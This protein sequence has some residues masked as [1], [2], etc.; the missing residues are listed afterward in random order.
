[1]AEPLALTLPIPPVVNKLWV[2][3][4]TSTGARMV[5]RAASEAW[6]AEA[7]WTVAS[8]RAGA[9]IADRF[10]ALIVVPETPADIDARIKPILDA[11]QHGGAIANDKHCRSLRVE[12]DEGMESGIVRVELTPLPPSQR[13]P[14]RTR[15]TARKE[16][17]S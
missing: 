11:C 8:Q 17:T 1:M 6:A 7:K 2:P 5:K 12:I 10:A 4:R 9:C 16:P 14:A 13:A 15:A 3:V